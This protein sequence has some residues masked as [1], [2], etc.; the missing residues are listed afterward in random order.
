[1]TGSNSSNHFLQDIM[2]DRICQSHGDC[3]G[4]QKSQPATFIYDDHG[5]SAGKPGRIKILLYRNKQHE[6]AHHSGL[7][8]LVDPVE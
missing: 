2:A 7:K 6:F 8:M 1:M 5:Q 4:N 3:Y